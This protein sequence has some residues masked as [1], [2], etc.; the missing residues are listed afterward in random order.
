MYNAELNDPEML[1]EDCFMSFTNFS[2]VLA[3]FCHF[4]IAM[5]LGV[6]NKS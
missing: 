1:D 3:E 5:Q 4:K 6:R 2:F